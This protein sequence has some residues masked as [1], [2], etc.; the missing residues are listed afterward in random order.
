MYLILANDSIED[1]LIINQNTR[2]KFHEVIMKYSFVYD[3]KYNGYI[4]NQ[5]IRGYQR[6]INGYQYLFLEDNR[7]FRRKILKINNAIAFSEW[8]PVYKE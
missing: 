6:I 4:F 5:T 7:I 2:W 1:L 8:E 3:P